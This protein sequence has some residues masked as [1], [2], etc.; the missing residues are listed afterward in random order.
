[1]RP[2]PGGVSPSVCS[3]SGVSKTEKAPRKEHRCQP[4]Q[5]WGWAPK[6][7]L[8]PG[9]TFCVLPHPWGLGPFLH[10]QPIT[11]LD[12]EALCPGQ[13]GPG[14]FLLLATQSPAPLWL[15]CRDHQ[16]KNLNHWDSSCPSDSSPDFA[17]SVLPSMPSPHPYVGPLSHPDWPY[18]ENPAPLP[19]WPPKTGHTQIF[20]K[21]KSKPLP[22]SCSHQ[23]MSLPC[24]FFPPTQEM[25]ESEL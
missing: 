1:M 6:R 14:G 9:L 11:L 19:T 23:H 5:T 16:G 2:S 13:P 21:V 3:L 24:D 7:Q 4:P 20:S 12:I 17:G 15:Y 8:C 25:M 22:S 10:P 18:P